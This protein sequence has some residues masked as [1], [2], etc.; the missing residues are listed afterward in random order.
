MPVKKQRDLTKQYTLQQ[1]AYWA[2]VA[3]LV[4]FA[5]AFLLEKGFAPSQVGILLASGNLLSC[6]FQPLLA[7][8]ADRIGGNVLKLFTLALSTLSFLFL[9]LIQFL[10]VPQWLYGLVYLM[11]VFSLD[12]MM[13][14][15]NSICVAYNEQGM[16]INYGMGRG[17]GS[18]AYAFAALGIGKAMAG[19]G[20]DSMV[21]IVLVLLGLNIFI[22]LRYPDINK[23]A[24]QS[25]AVSECCTVAEFFPRYKWYC[26]SLLGVMLLA[27]FHAMTENY[28]IE[29][30]GKLGGD[31]GSVGIALFVATAIEAPVVI[32]FEKIRKY[33]SDSW[34]LRLA[35]LSF[36]LKS[37]LLLLAP[38]V[39]AI[40]FIQLLQATSY[41]FLSPTQ[42]Y[43]ANA[44]V[45]AADMVKGQAFITAA[46]SLGCAI[47]NFT[48]G[49]LL[50]IFNVT[51]LLIAGIAMAAAGTVI[52]FA[53]VDK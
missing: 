18:L 6:A 22:T 11:A 40:Y 39:T 8:Q 51:A 16:R 32:Y 28:L 29:I 12:A 47:G 25:K 42:M 50:Q 43:Y 37:V 9:C 19:F 46:Y 45:S 48:G 41:S 23:S 15:L 24:E 3:G 7:A 4:S 34:L 52:L 13:P 30:A 14:L 1:I 44:K 21:W 2:A 27:M 38:S 33:I 53:T 31:S 49:Q 36:L 17:L 20:A 35:G 10:P 5:T 26:V